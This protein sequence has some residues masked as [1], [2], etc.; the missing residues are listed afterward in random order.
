MLRTQHVKSGE[1]HTLEWFWNASG[2]AFFRM[3]S[4]ARIRVRYGVGFLRSNSQQQ[5]LDGS[6]YKK[7]TVGGASIVRARMQIKVARSTDVTYEIHGGGVA[8][9]FPT[10]RF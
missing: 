1:W 6:R 3:P 8:V 9:D 2:T 10:I 7:L 4:D 5:T